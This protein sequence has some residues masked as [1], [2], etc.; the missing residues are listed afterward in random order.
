MSFNILR[1]PLAF[2]IPAL[3]DVGNSTWIQ[4][5][6]PVAEGAFVATAD[7]TLSIS[8]TIESA[9]VRA[10]SPPLR[11]HGTFEYVFIEQFCRKL[12]FRG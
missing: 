7:D 9:H 5:L 11:C 4:F 2:M 8:T 12:F 6:T 1:P 10:L 3:Q